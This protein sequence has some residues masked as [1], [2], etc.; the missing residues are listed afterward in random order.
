MK[1]KTRVKEETLPAVRLFRNN[2][3]DLTNLFR[4]HASAITF[5]DSQ[6]FYD[7]LAEMREKTGPRLLDLGEGLGRLRHVAGQCLLDSV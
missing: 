5:S 6:Y 7:D 3:D 2:L 1:A 4:E